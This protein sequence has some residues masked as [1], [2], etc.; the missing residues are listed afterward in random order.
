MA[1]AGPQAEEVKQRISAIW[2]NLQCPICLDLMSVPVTT[3][4]DHQFCKFCM[5]KLLD[6]GRRQEAN[7][8]VCKTKVT[9]RSVQESSAFQKLVAGLQ[10]LVEAY[11][12]DTCTSYFTGLA[13]SRRPG[14]TEVWQNTEECVD[15]GT[16]EHDGIHGADTSAP[17]MTS[18]RAAKDAF[19]QL[20]DLGDSC[21]ATS[22]SGLGHLPQASRLEA[23]RSPVQQDED[24]PSPAERED[25]LPAEGD[26]NSLPPLVEGGH[27]ALS[28]A[29]VS[30]PPQPM[31]LEEEEEEAEPDRVVVHA[32]RQTRSS[33]MLVAKQ[34]HPGDSDDSELVL[35]RSSRGGK[36]RVLEVDPVAPD[37]EPKNQ[38]K[39]NLENRSSL[40]RRRVLQVDLVAHKEPK[41]QKN[42]VLEVDL[43]V[44]GRQRSLE[45]VS[46]WLLRIPPEE[47]PIDDEEEKQQQ[48]T[49]MRQDMSQSEQ[50]HSLR[51]SDSCLSADSP[52]NHIT[53]SNRRTPQREEGRRLQEQVFG[54]VYTRGRQT[55]GGQGKGRAAPAPLQHSPAPLQHSLAPLQGGGSP[56]P[57]ELLPDAAGSTEMPTAPEPSA[58]ALDEPEPQAQRGGKPGR[59]KR[60]SGALTPEDFIKRPCVEDGKEPCTAAQDLAEPENEESAARNSEEQRQEGSARKPDG[61]DPNTHGSVPGDSDPEPELGSPPEKGSAFEAEG[62]GGGSGGERSVDGSAFEVNEVR[63]TGGRLRARGKM[64]QDAWTAL[65]KTLS[66]DNTPEREPRP[67]NTRT[68][69]PEREPRPRNTRTKA[70]ER[71]PRPQNIR[72]KAPQR[73]EKL[74]E[75]KPSRAARNLK[76]VSAGAEHCPLVAQLSGAPASDGDD[77]Q[78]E[79]YPS[80]GETRSPVARATRRSRRLVDLTNE[81]QGVPRR[82][83]NTT[84]KAPTTDPPNPDPPNPDP[85]NPDHT[86][87][88]HPEEDPRA[89]HATTH[90]NTHVNAH[91]NAP[92]HGPAD[93]V[94]EPDASLR[95]GAAT[96]TAPIERH[97]NPERSVEGRERHSNPEHSVEGREQGGTTQTQPGAP[98]KRNGCVCEQRMDSIEEVEESFRGSKRKSFHLGSPRRQSTGPAP[99]TPAT[100]VSTATPATPVSTATEPRPDTPPGAS[101]SAGVFESGP[102]AAQNHDAAAAA[103]A[104]S[105]GSEVIPP[106][107]PGQGQQHCTQV[108]QTGH[109]G[110]GSLLPAPPEVREEGSREDSGGRSSPVT[111]KPEQQGQS[112]ESSMTPDGLVPLDAEGSVAL[113]AEGSV[114]LDAEGSVALDAEGSVALDAEGSAAMD[115][116]GS[117]AM[118]AEGSVALDAEGSVAMDAEGSVAM[119]AEGPDCVVLSVEGEGE[120]GT[121]A[122]QPLSAVRKRKRRGRKARR[123]ESSG[124]ELSSED[125]ELPSLQQ[126]FRANASP[127]PIG[128]RGRSSEIPPAPPLLPDDPEEEAAD[129]EVIPCSL[130]TPPPS[131]HCPPQAGRETAG[132]G[133]RHC[134][135]QAGRGTAGVG[136]RHCPPQAGRG[137]AAVGERHC[138]PQAGRGTAA[139]GEVQDEGAEPDEHH[140][141]QDL[142]GTPEE[143]EVV[144]EV[145]AGESAEFSQYSSDIINTQQKVEMQAELQRLE[146]MMALVSEALKQKEAEPGATAANG[147]QGATTVGGTSAEATNGNQG[148]GPK[149]SSLGSPKQ[150]PSRQQGVWMRDEA[151]SEAAEAALPSPT[152]DGLGHTQPCNTQGQRRAQRSRGRDGQR[153]KFIVEVS[154]AAAPTKPLPLQLA[155]SGLSGPQQVEAKRFAKRMGGSVTSHVTANTTHV[156]IRTDDELVCERTLKYFQGISNRTWVVSYLWVSE[157][158]RQEKLLNEVEFEVCGDVVNGRSHYGPQKARCTQPSNLLMKGFEI[159]FY[160]PFTGMST[161]QM[162]QMVELCGGVVV[163]DLCHF[164]KNCSSQLVIVQPESESETNFKIRDLPDDEV[165]VSRGWLLDS[166]ATYTLQD[167]HSYMPEAP[168]LQPSPP[169]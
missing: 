46:E 103:A 49:N 39:K 135:P 94:E 37:E 133:E 86:N 51:G 78:I 32:K 95:T 110:S 75:R 136:E 92:G 16:P 56:G 168:P 128:N 118:D 43:V 107:D 165:V 85:P 52:A 116:E 163:E 162:Q 123:L 19:A 4:C 131:R 104:L 160:G 132:V 134:P 151:S 24:S 70:Q 130:E 55:R 71:E 50:E 143:D 42:R 93:S 84:A 21:S 153:S 8:P 98:P 20:M 146:Q 76:L 154:P 66:A 59:R 91:V 57:D 13:Q 152:P 53:T 114:A 156:I 63:R 88:D 115:A 81:V 121:D 125:E 100:P 87:P 6:R 89:A 137:T 33:Q 62:K 164:S 113:D 161:G 106:S 158:L 28:A 83:R 38:K 142:F 73:D 72:P 41:N 15:I 119:D 44:D 126:I 97:G 5:Q 129:C 65:D 17:S 34:Q 138:P 120:G 166:I 31:G 67:R 117:A 140:G 109:Q 82:T 148:A 35:R 61:S 80:S 12:F 149:Q 150:Q 77:A 47:G 29:A 30:R 74:E 155:L 23:L 2:E 14:S 112:F 18:S 26:R 157:C 111:P 99:A 147:N 69:A 27:D 64:M 10:Q 22:D 40:G 159:C 144:P 90:V 45:K 60:K 101:P 139:V 102:N 36:R 1:M 25:D 58:A 124:S 48:S 3:K 79:S 96:A 145:P 108:P 54:A 105:C 127:Q 7:C 9:K 167:L 169:F 141:S 122:S 68:E 11:E